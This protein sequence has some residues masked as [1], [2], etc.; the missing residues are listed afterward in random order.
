M[1]KVIKKEDGS[2]E[3][4]FAGFSTEEY[5][6]IRDNL[7]PKGTSP[8]ELKMFLMLCQRKGLDPFQ[9][10]V[11]LIPRR[12]KDGSV[13][14]VVQASIDGYR[15]IAARTGEY[16]GNDD[17]IFDNELL[18]QKATVT[19]YRIVKNMKCAFTASARMEQYKPKDSRMAFMWEKMPHAM[20][21]FAAERLALRKGFP[22][23][24]S[25]LDEDNAEIIHVEDV[26]SISPQ[27]QEDPEVAE[28]RSELISL[29]IG[30]GGLFE[31]DV[32]KAKSWIQEKADKA[33]DKLDAQECMELIGS[34]RDEMGDVVDVQEEVDEFEE[35]QK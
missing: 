26:K 11:Y 8:E 5:K 6:M 28:M 17:P 22:E 34:A 19:V 18:P 4:T 31:K 29:L 3:K 27:K 33:F 16:A 20:L 9:K 10:Q 15:A 12:D 32:A 2:V 25:G 13:R 7:A 14:L 35:A 21:G 24:L 23:A 30:K 1:T